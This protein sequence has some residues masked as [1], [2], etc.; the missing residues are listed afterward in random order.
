MTRSRYVA[1]GQ[2]FCGAGR[3]R[4]D[5]PPYCEYHY[6]VAYRPVETRAPRLVHLARAV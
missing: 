1:D 5:K 6:R 3:W 2:R 4:H